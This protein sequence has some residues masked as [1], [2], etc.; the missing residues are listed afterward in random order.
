MVKCCHHHFLCVRETAVHKV[1][2]VH[3]VLHI[4]LIMEVSDLRHSPVPCHVDNGQFK[5]CASITHNANVLLTVRLDV[6]V[7]VCYCSIRDAVWLPDV[8]LTR[9][10]V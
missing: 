8:F 4:S 2:N 7:G 3:S 6:I 5:P 10:I 9:C 1:H